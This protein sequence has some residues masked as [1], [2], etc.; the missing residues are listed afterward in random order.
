MIVS[1]DIQYIDIH[2]VILCYKSNLNFNPYGY[3][4]SIMMYP[5]QA[6]YTIMGTTILSHQQKVS[7]N[8]SY[9]TYI[10]NN[11]CPQHC[12]QYEYCPV[13]THHHYYILYPLDLLLWNCPGN[14]SAIPHPLVPIQCG[15]SYTQSLP[16]PLDVHWIFQW[17]SQLYLTHWYP[18]N[19][20]FHIHDHYLIH[21]MYYS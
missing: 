19:V 20:E 11:T 9:P 7:F 5:R 21:W 18:F 15:I 2:V 14:Q 1:H 3:V 12:T 6:C 4:T 16:D 17:T 13:K 10:L 8:R